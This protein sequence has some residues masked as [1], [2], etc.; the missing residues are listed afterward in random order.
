MLNVADVER[1]PCVVPLTHL[2]TV[3]Q[4]I[5]LLSSGDLLKHA[6]TNLS[7]KGGYVIRSQRQYAPDLGEE[8][9]TFFYQHFHVYFL[10]VTEDLEGK[11]VVS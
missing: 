7:D 5:S 6:L 10:M 11:G 1:E 4:D 9:N 8:Q 3:A 2:G